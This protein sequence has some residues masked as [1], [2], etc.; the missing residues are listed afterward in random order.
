MCGERRRRFSREETSRVFATRCIMLCR[1]VRMCGAPRYRFL[2]CACATSL[3]LVC[4]G[5]WVP[6]A[7]LFC[8]SVAIRSGCSVGQHSPVNYARIPAKTGP[9]AERA[10][11]LHP[12]RSSIVPKAR[13]RRRCVCIR[14]RG[15]VAATTRPGLGAS[16]F[17][18]VLPDSITI[19]HADCAAPTKAKTQPTT[20]VAYTR[21]HVAL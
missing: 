14:P 2:G 19:W 15:R 5:H 12:A 17:F 1:H 4:G 3:G 7:A 6:R 10:G 9:K 8:S 16:S 18:H 21:G 20:P 13:L 11:R